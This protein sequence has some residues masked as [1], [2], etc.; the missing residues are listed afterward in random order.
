MARATVEH[1]IS[2]RVI[3]ALFEQVAERQAT[4]TLLLSSV[5]DLIGSVVSRG[6]PAVNAACRPRAETLGF[7]LKAVYDK[8][9]RTVPSVS[10]ALVRHTAGALGLVIAAMGG[11]RAAWLPGYRV[12]IIDGNQLAESEHRIE[13]FRATGAGALPGK[14]LERVMNSTRSGGRP[15]GASTC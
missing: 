13:E 9:D 6:Q 14:A 5:L 11:E 3:D 7:S 8:L 2:L 10:A 4:R 12:K 15:C 1:T